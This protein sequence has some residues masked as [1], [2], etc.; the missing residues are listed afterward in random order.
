MVSIDWRHS[1]TVIGFTTVVDPD[2]LADAQSQQ[3]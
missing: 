3:A 2:R 1:V